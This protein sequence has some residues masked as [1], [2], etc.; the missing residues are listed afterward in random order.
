MQNNIF[1]TP[2][3]II[4]LAANIIQAI[5]IGIQVMGVF[6]SYIISPLS[7]VLGPFAEVLA[8]VIKGILVYGSILVIVIYMLTMVFALA[9][10]FFH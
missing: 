3:G 7:I 1:Y 10:R 8:A 2:L 4:T 5:W 6:I 9:G